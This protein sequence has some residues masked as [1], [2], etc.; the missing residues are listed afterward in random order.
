MKS[1]VKGAL[2]NS[3]S[4]VPDH[5]DFD[6]SCTQGV[7]N[8]RPR[9]YR[10]VS[11]A[12]LS[13]LGFKTTLTFKNKKQLEFRSLDRRLTSWLTDMFRRLRAAILAYRFLKLG[14]GG[15]SRIIWTGVVD[16]P[17]GV[18]ANVTKSP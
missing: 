16:V 6:I 9:L 5:C 8:R 14:D 11:G 18:R 3:Q 10:P 15:R 13:P 12:P 7:G 4:R 1:L 2:L 17:C